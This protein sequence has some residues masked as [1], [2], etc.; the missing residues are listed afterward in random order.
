MTF[1]WSF[2]FFTRQI[3]L[4]STVYSIK[5]YRFRTCSK[6]TKKPSFL[7]SEAINRLVLGNQ[8]FPVR[9][10]LPAMCRGELSAVI[11][12]LMSKCP[13]PLLSRESWMFVKE[14]PDR[15]KK[16]SSGQTF[17]L[18]VFTGMLL[19]FWYQ[20]FNHRCDN[21]SH[22]ETFGDPQVKIRW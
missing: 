19:C 1:Y 12:R 21:C 2:T 13:L 18:L 11:T 9:V 5:S 8:R 15:K 10:R 22:Y 17:V 4:E 3:L 16:N 14:N 20:K 7:C 6:L